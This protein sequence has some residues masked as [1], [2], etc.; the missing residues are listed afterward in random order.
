MGMF[1][2]LECKRPLPDLGIV[3][4]APWQTKDFFCEM[5]TLTI[6]DDGRLLRAGG[7]F[8]NSPQV[9]VN[10][11]GD[12]CFYSDRD[13]VWFEYVARFTEGRLS[14]IWRVVEE[15]D[16]NQAATQSSGVNRGSAAK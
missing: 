5:A 6:T 13:G 12:L 14:R 4:G 10:Y 3:D 15:T 2:Q 7:L 11:H 8:N 1:D 16:G 9:E